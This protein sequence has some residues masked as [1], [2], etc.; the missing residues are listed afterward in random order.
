MVTLSSEIQHNLI[1]LLLGL[2]S[3]E[4][5]TSTANTTVSEDDTMRGGAEA[6]TGES[7]SLQTDTN[8]CIAV[9]SWQLTDSLP[10]PQLPLA[11]E[12]FEIDESCVAEE[13]VIKTGFILEKNPRSVDPENREQYSKDEREKAANAYV[14]QSVEDL[15]EKASLLVFS[16]SSQLTVF[17]ASSKKKYDGYIAIPTKIMDGDLPRRNISD[18]QEPGY[19]F[20]AVHQTH[21]NRYKEQEEPEESALTAEFVNLVVRVI[22]IHMRKLLPKE[23]DR[24]VVNFGVSTDAHLDPGDDELCVTFKDGSCVGGHLDM[25]E[26]G[27]LLMT[28]CWDATTFRSCEITHFNT[29]IKGIRVSLVLHSDKNGKKWAEER[30]YWQGTPSESNT[31]PGA[32]GVQAA[33]YGKASAGERM[34]L[35]GAGAGWG[36]GEIVDVKGSDKGVQTDNQARRP[37]YSH[38]FDPIIYAPASHTNINDN[39]PAPTI[40]TMTSNQNTELNAH[41]DSQS[42]RH[43]ANNGG[44]QLLYRGDLYTDTTSEEKTNAMRY[45]LRTNTVSL[46]T[47][48][49]MA[50]LHDGIKSRLDNGKLKTP[51]MAGLTGKSLTED[52]FL[53]AAKIL[54]LRLGTKVRTGNKHKTDDTQSGPRT[55]RKTMEAAG[56]TEETQNQEEREPPFCVIS[57]E[58]KDKIITEF[59][60]ATSNTAVKTVECSFCGSRQKAAEIYKIPCSQ[61]NVELLEKAVEELCKICQQPSV[62][63]YNTNTSSVLLELGR[64]GVCLSWSSVQRTMTDLVLGYA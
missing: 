25:V 5:S 51:T 6:G 61:L 14:V 42:N 44:P 4:P 49:S 53:R 46:E 28:E 19:R 29:E 2:A 35:D 30:N 58:E 23:Y 57:Q 20:C 59:I 64:Q 50:T 8:P 32:G 15:G 26:P 27:L 34:Q 1:Q 33:D 17:H 38:T 7:G 22:E 47:L 36:V 10:A 31:Q 18:S 37:Q 62:S 39:T 3:K 52:M 60:D 16:Y 13:I 9:L 21:Y 63:A 43:T 56:P 40:M 54:K 24:Y 12:D 48:R 41:D 55:K 45:L 11:I